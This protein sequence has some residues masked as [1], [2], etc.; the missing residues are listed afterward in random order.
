MPA[1]ATPLKTATVERLLQREDIG[2]VLIDEARGQVYFERIR[3][4]G[5]TPVLQSYSYLRNEDALSHLYSAPLNGAKAAAPLFPQEAD[6][7]FAVA[8]FGFADFGLAEL[9]EF[10]GSGFA[11]TNSFSP[12]RRYL[13]INRL[14]GGVETPGVYD[15]K[16]RKVHFIDANAATG[17]FVSWISP[18]AFTFKIETSAF[19]GNNW[20]VT[21]MRAQAAA[22]EAGWQHR[23]VTADPIGSG[24]YLVEAQPVKSRRLVEMNIRTG[25]ITPVEEAETAPVANAGEEDVNAPVDPPAAGARLLAFTEAGAVFRVDE[26]AIGSRLIYVPVEG[27]ARVLYTFNTHLA[28]VTPA[29]APIR[30]DHTDYQGE[31]AIGWLYL[32]PGGKG[33]GLQQYPLVVIS[34]P[35][36]AYDDV[37]PHDEYGYAASIWNEALTATTSVEV[38]AAQG[39]A[40]LLPSVPL[41]PLGGSGE[42]M[43]RMMPAVLSAVDAAVAT[44]YVDPQRLALSGQSYGGYGALAV[45]TQ[46]DRF[47][48]IIAM[49]V[50]A[51]LT[52]GYGQF[53]PS[54]RF[55]AAQRLGPAGPPSG[56][57]EQTGWAEN[58]QGRMGASPWA[59]PERYIRNSPLF[60]ADKVESPILILHGDLDTATYITQA[61]EMFTAL[62]REKKD[63]L[64]VRYWGEHHLIEQ[65]QNQRDMWARV[66]NFLRNN[67]V[68]PGPKSAR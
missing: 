1:Q 35:G 52:S 66:F 58:G 53:A 5:D 34:Y 50:K 57:G 49:A 6:A 45:A 38:F 7:G 62:H 64:F 44:G 51:N 40:V 11:A 41:G 9:T 21:G 39:Y 12:D 68:R 28:G 4:V 13:A 30:I 26:Y 14:K 10:I 42:P 46:T 43:M 3:P 54:A 23:Q 37:P 17:S 31:E 24:R 18:S 55:E 60:F 25:I 32:P 20:L 2:Q 27:E 36:R 48:A 16:T 61:E 15:F 33:D 47:N 56:Q 22:R 67:G 19:P 63:V 65:P 29:S 59:D 8:G